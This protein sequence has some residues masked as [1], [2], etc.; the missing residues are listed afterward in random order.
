MTKVSTLTSFLVA[1][2]V[3]VMPGVV[4]AHTGVGGTA[5]FGAG[6]SHP[7][8]GADHLLAMVAV[9]LWAAQTRG[10]ARWGIPAAFLGAMVLAGALGIAG[11][12][13]PFVEAGT[14][15]SVLVLGL[16]ITTASRF[17]LAVSVL[18]VAVFAVFH[19][20]AHGTEM[21]PGSGAFAYSAGF[22][23]A[24][25]LLHGCGIAVGI[26]LDRPGLRKAA[27]T[28]GGAIAAGG[29]YLTMA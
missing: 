11:V 26:A 6:L 21:P 7:V 17:P 29:L 1:S 18:V 24:T 15:A 16:L 2:V 14:L 8:G 27:R 25:A 22:V 23:L 28:A 9:G 5:G 13:V 10:R 20:H 4:L 12:P 19:G 3:W